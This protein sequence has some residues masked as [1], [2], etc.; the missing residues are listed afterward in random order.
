MQKRSKT[1]IIS[2]L[3]VLAM[4]LSTSFL[5]AS[6]GDKEEGS[7]ETQTLKY[8]IQITDNNG[9]IICNLTDR[10]ITGTDITI[11]DATKEA[12]E[13]LELD[14]V[15]DSDKT[16]SQI[17]SLANGNLKD[18]SPTSATAEE[19]ETETDENGEEVTTEKVQEDIYYWEVWINDTAAAGKPVSAEKMLNDGDTITWKWVIWVAPEK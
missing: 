14:V 19:G 13:F 3:T 16:V 8:S 18:G 17:A 7:G 5:L 4:L 11:S 1:K 10:E 6:C 9:D 15:V 2:I 12:C